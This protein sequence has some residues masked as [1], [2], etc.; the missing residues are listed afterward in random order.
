MSAVNVGAPVRRGPRSAFLELSAANAKELLRDKK[1]SFSILF[2]VG[3]LF[4]LML[5]IN[6]AV[7]VTGRPA[8]VVG[9]SGDA[10]LA[11]TIQGEFTDSGIAVAVGGTNATVTVDAES[12]S[13]VI[14]TENP[15]QWFGIVAALEDAGIRSSAITVVDDTGFAQVDLLRA[16]LAT[17]AAIGFMAIT[18][19]GTAVPVVTMRERGTLRL[20]GTTPL[21]KLT[22]IAAQTP[23]RAIAGL[24]V[25]TV[26]VVASFA[27]GY[28]D[29][30]GLLRLLVTFVLGLAMF[31][32]FA[33]LLASRSRNTEVINSIAVLVPIVAM[34]AS[35]EVFPK[36]ILPEWLQVAMEWVPSS[37]FIQAASADLVGSATMLPV[38]VLWLMMVAS[39]ALVTL[40]AARLFVWDDRER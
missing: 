29:A 18:F 28:T 33:Y 32:A 39:T 9:V 30:V 7:N 4:V 14:D 8:P 20:L 1:G 36:Q 27:L 31:F 11:A 15:P 37:W 24:I 19:M 40:L 13:V 35:G 12:A 17:I 2:M 5:G 26:V 3:F 38:P 6:Q 23:A 25:G 10:T 16:N 22:F 34:F 21:R